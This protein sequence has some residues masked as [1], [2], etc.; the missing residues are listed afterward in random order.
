M[1]YYALRRASSESRG[2]SVWLFARGVGDAKL[3][4][5]E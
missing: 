5:Y 3:G 2:D 1:M 4:A